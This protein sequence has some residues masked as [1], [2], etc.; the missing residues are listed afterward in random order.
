MAPNINF[1]VWTVGINVNMGRGGVSRENI[2][3][4]GL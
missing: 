1:T 2:H 3:G 4:H